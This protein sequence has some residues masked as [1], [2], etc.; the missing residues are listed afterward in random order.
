MVTTTCMFHVGG[1]LVPFYILN[2]QSTLIFN[3]GPDIDNDDTCEVL[4]QEIDKF[5]PSSLMF[6]SH[7]FIQISKSP[8]KDKYLDLSSVILAFPMGS[9]I[10]ISLYDDLK[11]SFTKLVAIAH[12]YG[13]TE[14]SGIAGAISFDTKYGMGSIGKKK[15]WF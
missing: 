1:F 5:K 2:T 3:H 8:P 12:L 11:H 10:P 4:Y 6:G 14:F 9:S 13:M 15:F 7:H